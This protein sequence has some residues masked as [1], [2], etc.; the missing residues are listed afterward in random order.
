MV[1][2]DACRNNPFPGSSKSADKG[3]SWSDPVILAG[4]P[5]KKNP[6]LLASWQQPM[7]SKSGRIY[8]L[9]NQQTTSRG[10][11]CGQMFGAYSDD[12]G[13]TWSAPKMVPMRRSVLDDPDPLV[14]PSWCNWSGAADR[15]G[16][17]AI[18]SA[19]RVTESSLREKGRLPPLSSC[20]STTSTTILG[21]CD[22][23]ERVRDDEHVLNVEHSQVRFGREEIGLVKLTD[24]RLF[25]LMRT[26][27]G[28]PYWSQSRDSGV[29]WS[30]PKTVLDA[31][32]HDLSSSA[33]PCPYTTGRAGSSQRLLFRARP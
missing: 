8:C 10:P 5:N 27:A 13:D 20:S 31:T 3:E 33:S 18:S 11:H 2:L 9:W 29:S 17:A 23:T 32:R 19:C 21:R 25:G 14:P 22:Q 28:H 24:G 7:I 15:K 1:V 12:K 6:A 30:E 26:C 4:S 16:R